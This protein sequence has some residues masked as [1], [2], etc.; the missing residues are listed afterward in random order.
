MI[1]KITKFL[2]ILTLMLIQNSLT[3]KEASCVTQCLERPGDGV[4]VTKTICT[5]LRN[6]SLFKKCLTAG[7]ASKGA[8]VQAATNNVKTCA[9][10]TKLQHLLK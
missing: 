4:T 8:S 1:K 9:M 6:N 5:N 2:G 7:E 3:A 10:A